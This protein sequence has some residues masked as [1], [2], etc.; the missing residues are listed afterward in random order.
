MIHYPVKGR[1]VKEIYVERVVALLLDVK[2]IISDW[3]AESDIQES[4]DGE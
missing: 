4:D 1:N 3:L 2:D